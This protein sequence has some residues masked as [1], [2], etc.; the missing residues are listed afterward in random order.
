MLPTVLV[1]VLQDAEGELVHAFAPVG[2]ATC[3]EDIGLPGRM[4]RPGG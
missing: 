4:N 1:R 3:V 2:I